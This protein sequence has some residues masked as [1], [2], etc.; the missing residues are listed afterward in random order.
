MAT[1]LYSWKSTDELKQKNQ[2]N[3][4]ARA[5]QGGAMPAAPTPSPSMPSPGAAP[6]PSAGVSP[7]AVPRSMAEAMRQPMMQQN[8]QA[9]QQNISQGFQ[10]LPRNGPA[11]DLARNE[12][13]KSTDAAQRSALEQSALGRRVQT[14]QATG[15]L[16]NFLTQSAIP[17]KANLEAN[18]QANRMKEDAARAQAAQGNLYNLA[19]LGQQADLSREQ[20]D[21]TERTSM[22]DIASREKLG[23]AGI[24]SQEG[25]QGRDIASREKLGQA[26]ITSQEAMQ[27][28]E[29]ASKEKLGFA[30]LSVREKQLAQDGSQFKDELAF[31]KYA[32]DRGF[33]DAEAQR[34]WQSQES[35]LQRASTE[36]LGMADLSLRERSL[37]QDASQFQDDLSFKKYATDRGYT[38]AEAQRAWQA[39]QNEKEITSRE[40]LGFADL[41]VREKQLAQAGAQFKDELAFKKYATDAGFTDAEAQRVWQSQESSLQR[42]SAEKVSFAQL[43]QQEKELALKA[44][45]FTDQLSWDKEAT[46]LGLDEKTSERV[47]QGAENQKERDARA[48]DSGLNRE[49]QK[50][51]GERG[52]DIDEQKVAEQ[53]RQ[54]DN[55]A[56][57][58]KWATQAGLDDNAADRVWKSQESDVQRK[59]ETGERLSTEEAQVNLTRLEGDIAQGALQ[60]QHV[61][62]LDTMEKQAAVDKLTAATANDYMVARDSAAMTH[63]AAMEQMKSNLTAKLQEAGYDHETALQAAQL[64]AQAYEKGQDRNAAQLEAQ[65]ELAYKYKALADQSGLSQ[66]EIDIKRQAT[67][68][69]ISRGLADLG[70]DQ[71]KF[72]QVVKTQDF[73]DR[74]GVLSTMMELGGDNPDVADRV[75]AGWL[76]LMKEKG[77]ISPEQYTLGMSGIGKSSIAAAGNSSAGAGPLPNAPTTGFGSLDSGVSKNVDALNSLANGNIVKSASQAIRGGTEIAKSGITAPF[78]ALK[79]I[80]GLF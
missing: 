55:E 31:K 42:A 35:S 64:Q 18:L 40:K 19:G 52:L 58:K 47:W 11:D 41:S 33:T 77:M 22:A 70:L 49:L 1:G 4:M 32:T 39:T 50:Y 8:L 79:A 65:A 5:M 6:A 44:S 28:R 3:T 14:G 76:G 30:D 10:P 20:M 29:L 45:Q 69:E 9:A 24:T 13:Q 17:Q 80:G 56:D 34:A 60:F 16:V 2:A 72:D 75:A 12:L 62:N 25:M 37:M 54:F 57:F 46:K 48:A 71:A 27:G 7:F 53:I 26:G 67:T 21:L 61:L 78:K 73:Q 38:D 66:Q 36:K 74:S 68:A 23:I 51:L 59:Y 15:D 43:S 63:D